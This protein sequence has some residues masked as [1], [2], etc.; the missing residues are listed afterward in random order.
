MN[1]HSL[2]VIFA[3][4]ALLFKHLEIQCVFSFWGSAYGCRSLWNCYCSIERNKMIEHH[5][6]RL[7]F[8]DLHIPGLEFPSFLIKSRKKS[9][10][11]H[12]KSKDYAFLVSLGCQHS[13]FYISSYI[14]Y[15]SLQPI[16]DS[17]QT[18]SCFLL[19]GRLSFISYFTFILSRKGSLLCQVL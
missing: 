13:D 11:L 15:P 1:S 18:Y 6:L 9:Y 4:L 12:L 8:P 10:S 5:S 16:R 3:A 7:T 14:K 2:F 19:T 17:M